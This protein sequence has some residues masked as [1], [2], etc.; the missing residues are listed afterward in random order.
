MFDLIYFCLISQK[1]KCKDNT[2]RKVMT[3]RQ[4]EADIQERARMMKCDSYPECH[5]EELVYHCV[6]FKTVLVEVCAPYFRIVC[7]NESG[8]YILMQF[9]CDH[10]ELMTFSNIEN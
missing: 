7:G 8:T 1:D 4:G 2:P 3:C 9:V 5:G 6:R 10:K